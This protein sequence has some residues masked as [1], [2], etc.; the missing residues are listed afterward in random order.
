MKNGIV[1]IV[2]LLALF[3][4]S[5]PALRAQDGAS[6]VAVIQKTADPVKAML[7]DE[8]SRARLAGDDVRYREAVAK[9]SMLESSTQPAA[10]VSAEDAP[11][12]VFGSGGSGP[13]PFRWGGD[14]KIF[15]GNLY[16]P[17]QGNIATAWDTLGNIYAVCNNSYFSS[18]PVWG[19]NIFYSA[20]SGQTWDRLVTFRHLAPRVIQSFSVSVTDTADG[21]WVIGVLYTVLDSATAPGGAGDLWYFRVL[22]NGTGVRFQSVGARTAST[23]FRNAALTTDG[24]YYSPGSTWFYGAV[25]RVTLSTGVS[26]GITAVRTTDGGY[27]W[28]TDTTVGGGSVYNDVNPRIGFMKSPTGYD[29]LFIAVTEYWDVTYGNNVGVYYNRYN[30]SQVWKYKGIAYTGDS[31]S[32]PDIAISPIDGSIFIP[33]TRFEGGAGHTAVYY[34]W[35][36]DALKTVTV[37]TLVSEPGVDRY[38]VTACCTPRGGYSGWRYALKAGSDSVMYY[39][40]TGSLAGLAHVKAANMTKVNDVTPTGT[41]RPII[42]AHRAGTDYLG[43][44]VY[45]GWGPTD[46]YFD[47]YDITV[48]VKRDGNGVPANYVLNQNYPNPFNPKT[49]ISFQLPV[50]SKVELVVYDILGREVAVLVNEQKAPGTYS[51]SF[52]GIGLASGIYVYRLHATPAVAGSGHGEFVMAKK[53]LLLK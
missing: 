32:D 34:G 51:A 24:F 5:G 50:V 16:A 49:V 41:M 37:D 43:H 35:S 31:E 10:P 14:V 29:S 40:T 20:D 22:D 13:G 30:F 36:L 4:V 12:V 45:A 3:L 21:R 53:L 39:S 17:G 26:R 52:D 7:E 33:Y 25:E 42:G 9:L 2:V 46:F 1:L 15:S 19:V 6:H 47:G 28:I 18:E 27:T 44:V 11:Q 23:G 38:A 48:D 8:I